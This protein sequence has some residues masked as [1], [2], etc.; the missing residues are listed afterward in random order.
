[1]GIV[2]EAL[3]LRVVDRRGE[4]RNDAPLRIDTRRV[5]ID[6]GVRRVGHVNR[7]ASGAI[8]ENDDSLTGRSL[9]LRR[10]RLHGSSAR[11]RGERNVS[12]D[13]KQGKDCASHLVVSRLISEAS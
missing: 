7:R 1:M 2:A 12:E 10:R 13:Q 11:R 3:Q 8:E 5:A 9:D 4:S 6:D